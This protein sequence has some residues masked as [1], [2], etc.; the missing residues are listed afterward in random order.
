MTS[1]AAMPAKPMT[2]S[3]AAQNITV[4]QSMFHA[5]KSVK[6]PDT[7]TMEYTIR[8]TKV[9]IKEGRPLMLEHQRPLCSINRART[10]APPPTGGMASLC[11]HGSPDKK[12]KKE[13]PCSK[14]ISSK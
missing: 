10:K 3:T 1:N 6:R 14:N 9:R 8:A 2:A 5:R 4:G 12:N 11:Q 7:A 13:S